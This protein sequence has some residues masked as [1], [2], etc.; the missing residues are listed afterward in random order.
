AKGSRWHGYALTRDD[1]GSNI[2]IN[3][4]TVTV[5]AEARTD[6]DPGYALNGLSAPMS[7]CT[8]VQTPLWAWQATPCTTNGGVHLNNWCKYDPEWV[9][10]KHCQQ[11]CFDS[12][13]GYDGDDCSGGWQRREG[14]GGFVCLVEEAVGGVVALG[15]S[16]ACGPGEKIF[17]YNPRI[18]F[19][20]ASVAVPTSLP[21]EVAAWRP[22]LLSLGADAPGCDLGIKG[23]MLKDGLFYRHQTRPPRRA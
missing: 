19:A 6:I 2:F 7:D 15:T 8:D 4:G 14:F 1:I 9:A 12:G 11:S 17:L 3:G 13:N 23:F 22:G 10:G 18:W 20:D 21:F 16:H 5:G